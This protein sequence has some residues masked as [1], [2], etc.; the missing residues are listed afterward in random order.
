[1]FS[2]AVNRGHAAWSVTNPEARQS[3]LQ[4]V[5]HEGLTALTKN[6]KRRKAFVIFVYVAQ[7]PSW[8]ILE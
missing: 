1:M 2:G 3:S 5:N 7:R 8:F 4:S 6:T